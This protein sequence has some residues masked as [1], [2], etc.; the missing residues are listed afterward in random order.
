MGPKFSRTA[1]KCCFCQQLFPLLH[2]NSNSLE[3]YTC[4]VS[5]L[6]ALSLNY[7]KLQNWNICKTQVAPA[8]SC[9][10][11]DYTFGDIHQSPW[12]TWFLSYPSYEG[13]RSV[14]T[15][16]LIGQKRTVLFSISFCWKPFLNISSLLCGVKGLTAMHLRKMHVQK[17][18][19][20]FI[21][22]FQT[23]V[24]LAL[25]SFVFFSGKRSISGGSI[26]YCVQL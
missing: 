13:S 20:Q 25:S 5:K 2:S 4:K 24:F 22:Q 26:P 1:Q 21:V 14:L 3:L 12:R 10:I 11:L 17:F 15:F 18:Y 19:Q 6:T 23:V 16:F 7:S 8:L 9:I